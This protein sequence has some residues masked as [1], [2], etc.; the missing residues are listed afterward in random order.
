MNP[1][2]AWKGTENLHQ[3]KEKVFGKR[4][5]KI[6][7]AERQKDKQVRDICKKHFFS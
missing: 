5:L 1:Q 6:I 4:G 2:G 3:G 7:K